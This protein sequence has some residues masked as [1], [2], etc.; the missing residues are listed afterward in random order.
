MLSTTVAPRSSAVDRRAKT[1][2]VAVFQLD[3]SSRASIRHSTASPVGEGVCW[4]GVGRDGRAHCSCR[5]HTAWGN[6]N[7]RARRPLRKCAACT[8]VDALSTE[9]WLSV[10]FAYLYCAVFGVVDLGGEVRAFARF[11]LVLARSSRHSCSAVCVPIALPPV[12]ATLKH[13]QLLFSCNA[14]PA[15]LLCQFPRSAERGVLRT[16]V[17][18][19]AIVSFRN[20]NCVFTS[21]GHARRLKFHCVRT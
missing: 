21:T 12:S 2:G 19:F 10:S 15:L 17:G 18:R 1:Q 3:N 7:R 9:N 13:E 20:R 5:E 6:C 16:C 8:A 4:R 11:P 14:Y